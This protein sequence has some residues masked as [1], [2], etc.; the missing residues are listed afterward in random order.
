MGILPALARK[1]AVL[2]Y[3]QRARVDIDLGPLRVSKILTVVELDDLLLVDVLR[4]L[5]TFRQT[6]QF[7]FH[8]G[9][10]VLQVSRKM[11]AVF[12]SF[13]DGRKAAASFTQADDVANAYAERRDVHFLAVDG[14]VAVGYQLAR[15]RAGVGE[16]QTVNEVVQTAF[17]QEHEVFAGDT[18]K[19][20]RF[21][22]QGAELLLAQTVHMAQFLF[23]EQL[24]AVVAYF[25]ALVGTMLSRREWAFQIFACTAQGNAKAAAE[26]KFRTSVTCH[27]I[28]RLLCV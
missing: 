24:C 21:L 8:G 28:G 15:S 12:Q 18:R 11:R 19:F 6:D 7:A 9:V 4:Q 1:Q 13:L 2:T 14:Y 10:V 16:A 5:R 26:F 22:E 17:K 23:L 25:S 20:L 3:G 27:C